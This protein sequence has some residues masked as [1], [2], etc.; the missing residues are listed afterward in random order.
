MRPAAAAGVIL[1]FVPRS[2]V[3]KQRVGAVCY[4]TPH[5]ASLSVVR[6]KLCL[7]YEQ[8][9]VS[10]RESDSELSFVS[11]FLN[12]AKTVEQYDSTRQ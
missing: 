12:A 4:Q 3:N 6:H 5:P 2:N 9:R 1:H 7:P 11:V 10:L 8:S